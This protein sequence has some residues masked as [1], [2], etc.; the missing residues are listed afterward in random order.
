[1]DGDHPV[2]TV[3]GPSGSGKS[4]LAPAGVVPLLRR[5]G[6]EI[7]V[8]DCNHVGAPRA[9]LATELFER[10]AGG[11]GP[12]R[13]E[14][15]DQVETW[16][17]ELGLVDAF[18][19]A[20]GRNA[21][22]LLVVLDQTEALLNL[23]EPDLAETLGLLFPPRRTSLRVLA[24]LRADVMNT[25]LGHPRLAPVLTSGVTLPLTPMTRDQLHTVVTRPLDE[26]PG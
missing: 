2:V 23:P 9:A 25:A 10:A 14:H 1:L 26:R 4:S 8:I 24:T 12:A 22:R 5:S 19:R 20:T 11:S 13:A 7:L 21:E 6:W 15:A 17:R 3:C 18:H 16:L